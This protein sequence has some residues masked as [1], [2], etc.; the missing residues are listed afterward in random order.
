MTQ[1]TCR[2]CDS[3][4]LGYYTIW[5]GEEYF[6]GWKCTHC[7]YIEPP[8]LGRLKVRKEKKLA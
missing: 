5:R 2:E 1:W 7:G 6:A 3:L 8:T 4:S